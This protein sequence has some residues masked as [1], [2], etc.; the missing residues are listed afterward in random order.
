MRFFLLLSAFCWAEAVYTQNADT[1]LMNRWYDSMS[2]MMDKEPSKAL[3]YVQK[4]LIESRKGGD[5]LWEGYFLQSGGI[6]YDIAN[7][8]DSGLIYFEK[9]IKVAKQLLDTVMEANA[10]GNIGVAYQARGYLQPALTYQLAA[11]RLREH[12][13]N[14]VYL[15]KS[16]NNIG[17]LY[18]MKKDYVKGLEYLNKSFKIKKQ[19]NDSTGMAI[20]LLNMGS[21]YQHLKQYDS[22]LYFAKKTLEIASIIDDKVIIKSASG[23]IGIAL[24]GK[25]DSENAIV[26]LKKG[27][28]LENNV[29][30]EEEIYSIY[31]SIATYYQKKGDLTQ[32]KNYLLQGLEKAQNNNRREFI[33][34]LQ[35]KLALLYAEENQFEASFHLLQK[36]ILLSDSLLNEANIRQINEMNILYETEI[37]ENKIEALTSETTESKLKLLQGSKQR[38]LLLTALVFSVIIAFIIA[39][40]LKQNQHK[41]LLLKE[42]KEIIEKQLKDKE[43]LMGEI[44]HR[45]KNNLQIISGLLNLQSRHIA[46]PNALQAVREGRNR[47][48]SIALIHQQ[49]YQRDS[50]TAINLNNYLKDLLQS[51]HQSFKDS[52]KSITHELKCPDTEI[53]VEVAVPI[54][55][56]INELV[57][58]SYKYAFTNKVSG[59]ISISITVFKKSMTIVHSDNG[60]G[61]PLGFDWKLQKSFGIKMV[62][63]LVHKLKGDLQI[64]NVEDG[65]SFI[66]NIPDYKNIT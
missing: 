24:L 26:W 52:G 47:V 4:G 30:T 29:E 31:Q 61:L 56:I 43:L 33:A 15:S 16:Y 51:I 3:V 50:L 32:S 10:L 41:N 65:A 58:N 46:D 66:I 6:I 8:L 42:Q 21:C 18:R 11:A 62:G 14:Q 13:A 27:L 57:T 19:A 17:L 28:P 37:K 59:K 9:T 60:I 20:T 49:L 7:Q 38:N 53:D 34:V 63:T 5:L 45:V 55:L 12:Q 48:K 39:Y 23:N 22:A 36:S 54:G 64:N 40:A 2:S 1:A 25:G 44:H 35:K